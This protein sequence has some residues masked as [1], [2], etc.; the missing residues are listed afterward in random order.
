MLTQTVFPA[1]QLFSD[2]FIIS[3]RSLS[4]HRDPYFGISWPVGL[5]ERQNCSL[6]LALRSVVDVF[7]DIVARWLP[8]THRK[9]LC[10]VLR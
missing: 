2:M 6:P 5:N 4:H 7:A 3:M 9:A 8:Q 10:C 1:C